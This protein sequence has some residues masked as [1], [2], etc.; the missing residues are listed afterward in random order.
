MSSEA[1]AA[2]LAVIGLL[3]GVFGKTLLDRAFD[4]VGSQSQRSF[5]DNEQARVWLREQLDEAEKELRA[6]R[7]NERALLARVGDLA[8]QVARQEERTNAQTARIDDLSAT[9]ARLGADYVEMK[10]ERDRY[11][12]QKHDVDNRLTAE[13]LG[14][15]LAERD[16]AMQAQEIERLRG[17][18]EGIKGEQ[19]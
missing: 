6:V 8:A 18:L 1:W 19:I 12:D 14:R 16:R 13:S 11:R 2:V 4:R 5:T 9:V 10:A 3:G 15:Q 7:E 17:Q